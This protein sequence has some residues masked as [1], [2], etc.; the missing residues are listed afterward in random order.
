VNGYDFV[1]DQ[2]N[3]ERVMKLRIFY[4][5][6]CLAVSLAAGNSFAATYYVAP[7]GSDSK[8]GSLS[9]PWKTIQYGVNRMVSGDTLIVR[10][11]T[12]NENVTITKPRVTIKN[13]TGESPILDGQERLPTDQWGALIVIKAADVTV[14]GLQLYRSKARGVVI[15]PGAHRSRCSNLKISYSW[16][17]GFCISAASSFPTDVILENSEIFRNERR[18]YYYRNPSKRPDPNYNY[19]PPFG[20]NV[21]LVG[22]LRAIIRNNKI[23]ESYNEG[24]GLYNNTQGALVENNEMWGSLTLVYLSSSKLCTVRNNIIY[25]STSWNG[26]ESALGSA[27]I[28]LGGENWAA[29]S[30]KDYGHRIYG[31]CMANSKRAVWIAGQSKAL[32]RNSY[33]YNNLL[34]EALPED[35]SAGTNV[36]VLAGNGGTG[37]IL[38]NN[39]VLQTQPKIDL[40]SAP[41]RVTF[42]SNLWS[43][44]PSS[45]SRGSGD[46][47]S[48]FSLSRDFKTGRVSGGTLKQQDFSLKS[49]SLSE[50][51]GTWLTT[52]NMPSGAN[53][54]TKIVVSNAGYFHGDEKL[55][56]E[57]GMTATIQSISGNTLTVS[58][59][60]TVANGTGLALCSF[61]STRPNIGPWIFSSSSGSTSLA[62]PTDL[63]ITE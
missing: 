7:S 58:P 17:Q 43:Q 29:S 24:L 26:S 55:K 15:A 63:Q 53:N 19:D 48:N 23:Y 54:S 13:Y 8:S 1:V 5:V 9:A 36:Q 61:A 38:K 4:S 32:A 20:A 39:A 50:N 41:N 30:S 44:S 28:W 3:E 51:K 33:I 25:G 60:V 59:A 47:I 27:A 11:G 22:T 31:N 21:S 57:N 34:V 16:R 35:G 62:T 2:C 42:A 46:L 14:G 52:V 37:N 45:A 40:I 6:L 49:T 56:F 10:G 18:Y 12:Y